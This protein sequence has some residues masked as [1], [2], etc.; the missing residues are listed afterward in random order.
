MLYGDPF[1]RGQG[2][3][4]ILTLCL[5]P[6]YCVNT[7]LSDDV[8][9]PSRLF[10]CYLHHFYQSHCGGAMSKF[11]NDVCGVSDRAGLCKD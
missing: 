11:D 5:S 8:L 1:C 4:Y 7:I 2:A 10:Q 6:D 3:H 9:P